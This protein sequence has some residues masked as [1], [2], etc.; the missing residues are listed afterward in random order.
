MSETSPGFYQVEISLP[1]AASFAIWSS[2]DPTAT[3]AFSEGEIV[4]T[5]VV[6]GPTLENGVPI[7]NWALIAVGL[8]LFAVGASRATTHSIPKRFIFL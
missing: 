1:A 8:M 7:A 2:P 3:F 4:V 6:A 5:A